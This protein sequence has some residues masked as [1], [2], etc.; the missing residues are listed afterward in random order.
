MLGDDYRGLVG[1]FPYA[2]RHSES[3]LFRSYA[4]LAG[5]L[6]LFVAVAL[7]LALV[8]LIASTASLRG[9]STTLS[10]AFFGVVG[11]L[12]LFPLVAPV[13]VVARR[14]RRRDSPPSARHDAAFALAGYLF[15]LSLYG[16]LLASIPADLRDPASAA[17]ALEPLVA[18]LYAAPPLSGLAFPVAASLLTL[19]LWWRSR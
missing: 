1:S 14:H 2:A 9:G 12:V 11:L 16:T 6:A 10:R 15:V 8:N 7:A 18:A 17:G 13:L 3:W 4:A 5:L 19:A